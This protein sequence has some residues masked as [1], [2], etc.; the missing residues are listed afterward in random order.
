LT[1]LYRFGVECRGRD[2]GQTAAYRSYARC[3]RCYDE[4]AIGGARRAEF[5]RSRFGLSLAVT[6]RTCPDEGD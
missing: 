4:D 6:Q 2:F 1:V 3:I 5:C